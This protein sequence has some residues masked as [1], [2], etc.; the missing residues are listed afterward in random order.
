MTDFAWVDLGDGRSVFRKVATAERKRSHLPAPMVIGDTM[1]PVQSMLDGQFYTSK[2]RL[3]ATY[4]AAGVTEVGNDPARLRPRERPKPD[5]KSIRR[6]LQKAASDFEQGRR[7]DRR[8]PA[9]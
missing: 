1:E 8:P 7:A 4:R 2:S 6:T 9:S 3:R 5:R